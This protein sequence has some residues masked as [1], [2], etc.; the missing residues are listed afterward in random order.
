[1]AQNKNMKIEVAYATPA[2]QDILTVEVED[3]TTIET[4][5]LRSGILER[6]PAIDLA[7][8]K[9]GIFGKLRELSDKVREG[10]RIEIYRPLVIDPKEARRAKGRALKKKKT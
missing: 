1:M 2:Q 8:Q 6:Y 3:G 4:A 9:V 10:D 7:R 5:I